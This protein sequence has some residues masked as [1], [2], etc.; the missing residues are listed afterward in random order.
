MERP[1]KSNLRPK[2]QA[3]EKSPT[4]KQ[5]VWGSCHPWGPMLEHFLKDRPCSTEQH[6]YSAWKAAACGKPTWD[7]FEKDRILWEGPHVEQGRRVFM[8]E[9]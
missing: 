8:K 5:K 2:L 7:Q 3:M 9:L 6:W 4:V 1:H